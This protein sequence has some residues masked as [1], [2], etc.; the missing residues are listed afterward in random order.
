MGCCTVR[1]GLPSGGTPSP[2]CCVLTW[3]R[4]RGSFWG[5]YTRALIYAVSALRASS[6]P[7]AHLL[8]PAPVLHRHILEGHRYLVNNKNLKLPQPKT[9]PGLILQLPY[10]SGS[11]Q[12]CVQTPVSPACHPP[13]KSS[14]SG[15]RSGPRTRR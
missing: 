2:A 1:R 6:P 3:W 8:M 4:G 12:E 13:S 15:T 14:Y 5:L 10:P 11:F 9:G 7:K